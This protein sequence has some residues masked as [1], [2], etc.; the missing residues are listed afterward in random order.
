MVMF[1]SSILPNLERQA[2][3]A[4]IAAGLL[5]TP[6]L[7]PPAFGQTDTSAA[8]GQTTEPTPAAATEQRVIVSKEVI[9]ILPANAG[10]IYVPQ[11]DALAAVPPAPTTEVTAETAEPAVTEYAAAEPGTGAEPRVNRID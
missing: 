1:R 5:L 10:I 9:V 11:Y 6:V 3:P 7:T 4:L 2:I 8:S